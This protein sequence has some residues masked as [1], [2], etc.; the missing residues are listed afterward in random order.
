MVNAYTAYSGASLKATYT[1]PVGCTTYTG[2]ISTVKGVAYVPT[3]SGYTTTTTGTHTGALAGP[4][5]TDF[6]LYL[7][8]LSSGTWTS[9]ASGT[10]ASNNENV[11]YNN[12]TAGSYRWRVLAYSGTGNFSLCITKPN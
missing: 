2:T 4:A 11:T 1:A 5:G 6:D 8:K 12:G 10:T 7:E 3:S 9:V